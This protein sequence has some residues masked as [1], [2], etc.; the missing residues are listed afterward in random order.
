GFRTVA[1]APAVAPHRQLEAALAAHPGAAFL[2]YRLP[3]RPGD[4]AMIR[5]AVPQ[6]GGRQVVV[7]PGGKVGG[8]LD[9]GTRITAV[10]KRI[11]SEVLIGP[12]GNR[13]VELAACWAI[14]MILSGLYLWWPRT[15]G[16]AGVV[17]PRFGRGGRALWRDVH[18]VAGFW[19]AGLA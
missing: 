11:H 6:V 1:G 4:A 17:W 8:A 19:V 15:G 3:E 10:T 16:L 18:A 5:L 13:L 12:L 14:V 2:D 9:P 7:S